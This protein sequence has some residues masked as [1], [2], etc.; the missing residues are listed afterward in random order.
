MASRGQNPAAPI[1]K[2]VAVAGYRNRGEDHDMI[3]RREIGHTGVMDIQHPDQRR[4]LRKF[5][6]QFIADPKFHVPSPRRMELAYCYLGLIG[7][8]QQNQSRPLSFYA[9]HLRRPKNREY[10]ARCGRLPPPFR[11]GGNSDVST[12]TPKCHTLSLTYIKAVSREIDDLFL[13]GGCEVMLHHDSWLE[14]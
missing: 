4:R 2:P 7:I 5:I 10:L 12:P 9:Y 3:R 1:A 6:L 13:E 14:Q 11:P 8:G